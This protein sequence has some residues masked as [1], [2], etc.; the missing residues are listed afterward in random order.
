MTVD[1][2]PDSVCVSDSDNGV[3]VDS[4]NDSG[5]VSGSNIHIRYIINSNSDD[6]IDGERLSSI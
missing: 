5:R 4:D 3:D 6:G 1:T 2:T